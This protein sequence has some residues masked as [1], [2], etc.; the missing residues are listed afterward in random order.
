MITERCQKTI[1]S[2]LIIGMFGYKTVDIILP[3]IAE[4]ERC[5]YFRSRNLLY[6]SVL[7][8]KM[9]SWDGWIIAAGAYSRFCS[10][11]RLGVFLLP[12]VGTLVHRR[13]FPRNVLD[14]PNNLPVPIYTPGWREALWELSVLPKNTTQCPR[15][16]IERGPLAPG[17]ST[18]TIRAPRLLINLYTACQ[19]SEKKTFN[20]YQYKSVL[21]CNKC[22]Y[23]NVDRLCRK[24]VHREVGKC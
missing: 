4:I 11:N 7:K 17:T 9:K 13:S 12:L 8:K 18:L 15:P 6:K 24:R 22:F 23:A 3:L 10:T 20:A 2:D 21:V 14:F 1:D 5:K 16:G 19:H